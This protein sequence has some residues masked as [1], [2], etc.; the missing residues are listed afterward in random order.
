MY[1]DRSNQITEHE[2]QITRQT[3]LKRNHEKIRPCRGRRHHY[4]LCLV[5]LWALECLLLPLRGAMG[6]WTAPGPPL[7]S[8][9]HIPFGLIWVPLR[10]QIHLVDVNSN[11]L[12]G[13]TAGGK[14]Q[15]SIRGQLVGAGG[16][17]VGGWSG[18]FKEALWALGGFHVAPTE[19]TQSELHPH[20][21][22]RSPITQS[23]RQIVR[24]RQATYCGYS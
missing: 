22:L 2:Q 12:R 11:G 9:G 16:G 7:G 17:R 1:I 10:L 4:G 8:L 18:R 14:L 3:L 19:T 23:D 5:R 20:N 15:D 13:G 6:L 24:V 21:R